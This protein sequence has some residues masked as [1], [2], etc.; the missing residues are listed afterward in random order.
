MGDYIIYD[1]NAEVAQA[2]S[3]QSN[4]SESSDVIKKKSRTRAI[5][6]PKKT[7]N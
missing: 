6:N 1:A 7:D 3:R 2:M 4:G 5:I